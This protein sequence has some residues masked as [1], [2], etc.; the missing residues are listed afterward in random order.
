MAES[1]QLLVD[2]EIKVQQRYT[3]FEGRN[4]RVDSYIYIY[5]TFN[6]PKAEYTSYL[7]HME[8]SPG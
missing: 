1:C 8:Y 5:K 4:M 2:H 7:M 6:P 3:G